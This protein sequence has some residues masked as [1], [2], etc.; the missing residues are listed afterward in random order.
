M[1]LK[2]LF[3]DE[4]RSPKIAFNI[5][6]KAGPL[7]VI[8]GADV[9]SVLLRT[10]LLSRE[11]VNLLKA[12]AV[13]YSTIN[14]VAISGPFLFSQDAIFIA[15]KYGGIKAL[16]SQNNNQPDQQQLDGLNQDIG[17]IVRQ[18]WVASAGAGVISSLL[19]FTLGG[20]L[21][22]LFSQPDEVNEIAY[23]YIQIYAFSLPAEY[24]L[25]ISERFLSAVDEEKWIIPY[26]LSTFAL[27]TG[28]NFILI[29]SFGMPGAAWS[30]L[31]KS[32]C[33][34]I[35]LTLF[36]G[37]KSNFKKFNIFNLQ[38][39]NLNY[40]K[41][42]LKQGLPIF[43]SQLFL[44]G[45]SFAISAFIGH[46]QK[47]RIVVEQILIQSFSVSEVFNMSVSESTNRIVA[48]FFGANNYKA[49]RK[50]GNLGLAINSLLSSIFSIL[51]VTLSNPISRL[52]LSEEDAQ[53]AQDAQDDL[54]PVIQYTFMIMSLAYIFRFIYD[55]PYNSLSGVNDTFLLPVMN[56]MLTYSVSLPL[57]AISTY[58]TD[59]DIYGI[60]SSIAITFM[61]TATIAL[62][63]WLGQS[64]KLV[65][66]DGVNVETSN[67]KFS[68][69]VHRFF[70]RRY[71]DSIP[72]S[73]LESDNEKTPILTHTPLTI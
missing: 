71:D 23:S 51:F 67:V 12:A 47:N 29:P 21:I 50:T 26:R 54:D 35:G 18:G 7:S 62:K 65:E 28:L 55:T 61:L 44:M 37:Y 17:V 49:V 42:I 3:D 73:E 32:L 63:Y 19:L 20:Q 15:E 14:I 66:N 1:N 25:K 11:D 24:M 34:S 13:V 22:K 72:E 8:Y 53:D 70:R 4:S 41:N 46:L 43:I 60:S 10:Y 59:F 30:A 27:Q 56:F 31:A 40:I 6:K 36:L 58:L 64:N 57:C 33:G 38:T 2:R 9:G 39:G 52:F 5:L 16:I 68:R 69:S 45:S 48:Q